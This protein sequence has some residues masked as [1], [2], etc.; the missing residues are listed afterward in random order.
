[1]DGNGKLR[2]HVE[3][4]S[5]VTTIGPGDQA[6][7][8]TLAVGT[9]TLYVLV[10]SRTNI[11]YTSPMTVEAPL[12]T[13]PTGVL[14]SM[15]KA[16]VF[17]VLLAGRGAAP[18]PLPLALP[19]TGNLLLDPTQLILVVDAQPLGG[20]GRYSWPFSIAGYG[21]FLQAI[22][23]DLTTVTGAATNRIP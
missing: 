10:R 18:A 13:S 6:R 22:A 19:F 3:N 14:N 20:N 1:M 21:G 8:G 5:F 9:E 7:G 17:H 2:F 16:G 4:S 15:G 11:A 23:V 12:W